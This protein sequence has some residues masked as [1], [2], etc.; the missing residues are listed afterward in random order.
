M[1][2]HSEVQ[3]QIVNTLKNE[4]N[5]QNFHRTLGTF[6]YLSNGMV[7]CISKEDNI[8]VP[9]KSLWRMK[10]SISEITIR[11]SWSITTYDMLKWRELVQKGSTTINLFKPSIMIR[12]F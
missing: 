3:S 2:G 9:N 1:E 11:K 6:I 4:E 12:D 5:L 10:F 8:F 7:I